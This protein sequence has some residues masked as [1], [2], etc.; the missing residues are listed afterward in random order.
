[1]NFVDVMKATLWY[2]AARN[3]LFDDKGNNDRVYSIKHKINRRAEDALD[4][5]LGITYPRGES[6]ET[7]KAYKDLN[8]FLEALK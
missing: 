8:K 7:Y 3:Q 4:V 2:N 1:M 5:A 6:F